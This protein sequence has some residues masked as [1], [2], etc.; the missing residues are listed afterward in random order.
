AAEYEA[1]R[2]KRIKQRDD[3]VVTR[4]AEVVAQL[5]SAEH[6]GRYL[7][8]AQKGISAPE[9]KFETLDNGKGLFPVIVQRWQAFL[10]QSA[11]SNDPVF[12]AW[13]RFAA[14]PADQFAAK[15]EAVTRDVQ[16]A[17]LENPLVIRF[18]AQTPP[19]TLQEVAQHYGKLLATFDGATAAAD[20]AI[21]ALRQAL[22]AAGSP[23]DVVLA[24][25]DN[26]FSVADGSRRR[27][28]Q[29]LIDELA[30][31]H[32][33]TPPRA[34]AMVDVENPAAPRIFKRGNPAAPGD[35]VPRRFPA[36]LSGDDRK[37]FTSGSGRLELAKAIASKDNP[38]TARVM[39]NR[40]W[41][42]HFG[43][44]LVR[45]PGDFGTRGE[46]PTHPELLDFLAR[47]FVETD[48]WSMKKLH[49]RMMMSSAYQQ[50]SLD[51]NSDARA[52]DPENRLL[53]RTNP[54]RLDFESMRDSLLV[55]SGQIDR[56]VGGRA[57]DVLAQPFV[58]RRS[59]YAYIDRQNLPGMFRTFDFASPDAT[60]S[61]R[62]TTSVPQQALFMMNSPFV[63]QQAK[64]VAARAEIA[65]E[66][67]SGKRVTQM[68]RT[69][70]GRMPK[71]PEVELG[72]NYIQTEQ[73][74]PP[75]SSGVDTTPWAYGYGEFDEASQR[76]R[77]FEPLPRFI[78]A[79]WQ[80]GKK[81]PSEKT[82]W[83]TLSAGGGHPGNDQLHAVVRRWTAPRDT[84]VSV[85]GALAHPAKEGDGVRARV[86]TARDGQ[87][88][89]WIVHRMS[90]ETRIAGITVK[91]GET[92]DFVVDCGRSND[93]NSD[94]FAWT[95]TITKEAP[96]EPVA[97]GDTGGSWDSAGQFAGPAPKPPTPLNA[98]EKYAQVLLQSNEFA[99]VD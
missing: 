90:A 97:G 4:H 18:V 8:A 50:A 29:Q 34:M 71:P 15:A 41:Q 19:K 76:M 86:I 48:A 60:S 2:L 28:L 73:A 25:A 53:W 51:N 55:A 54:H 69:V 26:I 1:E 89:Q 87:L 78:N 99:F 62:F 84:T 70:L 33:G 35:E 42:Y 49:K 61:Q 67:D 63:T 20:P 9:F 88:A 57:I 13:R 66:S 95:I 83:A 47:R 80:G 21:E 58:P 12:A 65:A 39:V 7:L 74:K 22:R 52:K 3:F 31:T 44:G 36:I 16:R 64:Q 81:L 17:A 91:A 43:A 27:Q 10:K 56:T 98:W 45:T 79:A 77:S 93:Y 46:L 85:A 68:Y 82:G 37:P 75:E 14:I 59:I 72:V 32:P 5:R 38:L 94:S 23:T 40:L 30:A 24:E 6:V 96:A 11:A 92:I